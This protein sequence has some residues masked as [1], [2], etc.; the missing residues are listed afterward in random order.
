MAKDSLESGK[1]LE[2]NKSFSG[3][4]YEVVKGRVVEMKRKDG[5]NARCIII[6]N[7]HITD[8]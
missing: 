3:H 2:R 8:Y 5:E 1:N 4:N 7:C 6:L